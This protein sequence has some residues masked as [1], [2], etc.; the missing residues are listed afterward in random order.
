MIFIENPMAYIIIKPPRSEFGNANPVINVER[1]DPRK[2]N[3]TNTHRKIPMKILS[4]TSFTLRRIGIEESRTKTALAS[5]LRSAKIRFTCSSC[6]LSRSATATVLAPDCLY[7][8]KNK[9]LFFFA[10]PG[11]AIV[12]K[13]KSLSNKLSP[14]E[15]INKKNGLNVQIGS[16]IRWKIKR[17]SFFLNG[18]F[19]VTNFS[20][21]TKQFVIPVNPYNPFIEEPILHTYK[22]NYKNI[23]FSLGFTL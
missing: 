13:A 18:G 19:N 1:A 23:F 14:Y 3:T 12:K 17:H 16:G 15:Y 4:R 6:F 22:L 7:A 20:F 10:K 5:I 8:S 2:K 11:L 21:L 9:A